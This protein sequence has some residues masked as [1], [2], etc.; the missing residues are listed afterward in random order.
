MIIIINNNN[1]II[2]SSNNNIII[3]IILFG[4]DDESEA[5]SNL[6]MFPTQQRLEPSPDARASNCSRP[7]AMC[8]P[9]T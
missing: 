6:S 3:I 9:L 1:T 5:G 4:L 7:K 8:L 2:I